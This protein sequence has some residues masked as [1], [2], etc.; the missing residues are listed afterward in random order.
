MTEYWRAHRLAA[1]VQHFCGLGY[2]R[3]EEPRGETSDNFT[4]IDK[5]VFE[6]N[7]LKFVRPAFSPVGL[8]LEQWGQSLQAGRVYHRKIYLI[9]DLEESW[10]GALEIYFESDG[11]KNRSFHPSSVSRCLPKDHQRGEL[12]DTFRPRPLRSGG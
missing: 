9:N 10:N 2:S 8:M 1:G 3:P 7:F 11:T 12:Q 5:L 6:P 4:D